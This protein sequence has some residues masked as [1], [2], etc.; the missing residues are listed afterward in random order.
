M[1]VWEAPTKASGD[2]ADDAFWGKSGDLTVA[3]VVKPHAGPNAGKWVWQL[4]NIQPVGIPRGA[5]VTAE[6]AMKAADAAFSRW[7]DAAG[8][9]RKA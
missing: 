1:L 8:L 6:G 3:L 5:R 2:R 4:N 9:C 7:C